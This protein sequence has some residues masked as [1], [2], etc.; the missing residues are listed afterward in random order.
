MDHPK[1]TEAGE[2]VFVLPARKNIEFLCAAPFGMVFAAMMAVLSYP[3]RIA[4][5]S[6]SPGDWIGFGTSLLILFAVVYVTA[7]QA[8]GLEIV[9][10]TARR[11]SLRRV[12]FSWGRARHF[13]L[14]RIRDLKVG[15]AGY[16]PFDP[17]GSA[18]WYDESIPCVCFTWRRET[19][20]FGTGVG[21][22]ESE[23]VMRKIQERL[24]A[25]ATGTTA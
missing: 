22:I 2:E 15:P 23:R 7:W 11:L 20:R 16:D 12:L 8:F 25:L 4:F 24:S 6:V 18:D 21:Y 19:V 9:T 5:R 3:G 14:S 13:E 1:G 17:L 10:L